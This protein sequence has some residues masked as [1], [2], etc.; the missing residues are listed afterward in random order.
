VAALAVLTFRD[1][2][3]RFLAPD[4]RRDRRPILFFAVFV[5]L[6]LEVRAVGRFRPLLL[7]EQGD[8]MRLTLWERRS[9]GYRPKTT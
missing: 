9:P 7:I 4:P 2:F 6:L 3:P 1:R 5:V 8:A